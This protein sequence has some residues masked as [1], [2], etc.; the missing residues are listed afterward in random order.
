MPDSVTASP[1][2]EVVWIREEPPP[3]APDPALRFRRRVRLLPAMA[4]LWQ[5]REMVR[6]LAEREL[7]A[8]Y[9]QTFLGIAWAVIT[10]LMLMV[11]F[12]VFFQRI[13]S[14]DTSGVPYSL[15]S[16]LGL[17]PWGFFSTAVSKG[18]VSLVFN[19][20]LLNK[21]SCPREVFPLA[22]I[23]VGGIDTIIGVVALLVLFAIEGFMPK[24]ASV[25]VPLFCV[26]QIVFS[27]GLVLMISSVVVYLRDLQATLPL[28]LQ[29]GLFATPVAW[30]LDS[31]RE[32]LQPLYVALNP[33]AEVIDGL[34][35]TVLHNQRPEWD[36]LGIAALSALVF[37]GV[38][39]WLFKRLETGIADVA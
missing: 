6:S 36:L 11:V 9:K 37:F 26:V 34:R 16:Y 32:S 15:F 27:I 2:S 38:G 13:A 30:G 22:N 3:E 1:P 5:S 10:P 20:P 7:R 29:L 39:Y 31:V 35:R 8:R 23:V 14:V 25:W 33:T 21:V 18:G 4:H 24:A 19:V 17:L 28:A 12:T